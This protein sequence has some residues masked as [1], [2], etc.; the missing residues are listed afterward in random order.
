M[1][2]IN[3]LIDE[4]KR[5]LKDQRVTYADLAK[6]LKLSES[7][8][9][10]MFAKKSMSLQRLEDICNLLRLEISD[11]VEAMHAQRRYVTELTR[12]QEAAL[13]A[14]PKLLLFAYLLI[15]GWQI[16]EVTKEYEIDEHEAERLLIRMHRAKL[17]ELLPLH[18]FKL[19]TARNLTWR[20]NGPVQK[21]CENE[22]RR[23]FPAAD[24]TAGD[25]RF[26]FVAGRLS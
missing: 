21:F 2:Q 25:A 22:V 9:K 26:R 14:D 6:A 15:H 1:A 5:R 12:D 23:E 7:S 16:E 8:V 4:L 24:F 3:L 13:V 18:R 19:L 11:I 17:V 10:R 20:R